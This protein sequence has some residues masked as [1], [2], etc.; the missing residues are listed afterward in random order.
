MMKYPQVMSESLL[1]MLIKELL[2]TKVAQREPSL[3]RLRAEGLTPDQK[4]YNV[5]GG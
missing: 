3:E 1:L 5:D 4:V 2:T